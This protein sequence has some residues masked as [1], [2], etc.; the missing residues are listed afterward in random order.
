MHKL[1]QTYSQV[2]FSS[3]QEQPS[4]QLV[5]HLLGSTIIV[6]EGYEHLEFDQ[7]LAPH[8]KLIEVDDVVEAPDH[9][10]FGRIL[11]SSGS[12]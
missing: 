4:S 10:M 12:G 1:V 7:M 11:W 9:L 5:G 2:N 8:L 3:V 6:E